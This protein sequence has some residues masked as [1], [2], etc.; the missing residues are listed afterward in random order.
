LNRIE[1]LAEGVTLHLGDCREILPT[2]GK[3]DAVISDPPYGMKRNGRYVC[4]K[5]GNSTGL[6][7]RSYNQ[8]IIGDDAAFDPTQWVSFPKVALFGSNHFGSGLPV[9][10]TLVWLKRKDDAFGTFLS[11][12]E[13]AWVKGGYGVYCKRGPFP[14]SLALNRLHPTQKPVEVMEWCIIRARVTD[15]DVILDPYMGSGSTGVAA[16]RLGHK[17]VGIEIDL[18]HFDTACRR[19]SA[20]A[21]QESFEWQP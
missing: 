11:D 3:I 9:G 5:N 21:K 8:K 16:I 20:T 1:H 10:T 19:L 4:G 17:F 15:G 14:Q 18:A 12:A 6:R 13:V 7:N 2:L